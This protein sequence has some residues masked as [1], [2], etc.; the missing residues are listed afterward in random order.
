MT[1]GKAT[2]IKEKN[3]RVN[4]YKVRYELPFPTLIEI[5]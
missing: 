4:D 3:T 5:H 1:M 2:V